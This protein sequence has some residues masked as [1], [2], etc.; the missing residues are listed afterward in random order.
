MTQQ[1]ISN[2]PG[3]GT[4]APAA[5]TA[6]NA[7]FAELYAAKGPPSVISPDG[8]IA[9][10]GSPGN[11]LTVAVST[12]L[13]SSAD[14]V[15]P[16]AYTYASLPPAS[17][18]VN[19]YAVTTDLGAVFSNGVY[20][21]ILFN[22]TTGV[23]AIA[24]NSPLTT[25]QQSSAYSVTL[26][27][28]GG[29]GALTWS[30][31]Q[32][33]GTNTWALSSSGV[34]T[35]TPG[36]VETDYLVVQVSDSTG[37]VVQKTVS[38]QTVAAL[39]P[40]ATPTFSPA[41]GTYTSTQT[42][43]ISDS[44]GSSTIY[45]TTNGS[46]PTTGSPVYSTPISVPT[47]QTLKAIATAAGFTQSAVGSAS[48]TISAAPPNP[49]GINFAAGGAASLSY[50]N[51]PIF[52]DRV[53]E[54]RGFTDPST[55]NNYV[56]LDAN[57]WPTV[58]W[59]MVVYE[60]SP[61]TWLTAGGAIASSSQTVA[62]PGV[63]TTA[64]QA[65]TAN[66]PVMITGTP[67]G[68]FAINTIYFVS[69]TGLTTTACELSATSGGAGIQCTSSS[70]CSIVPLGK[71][72]C[73]FT[74]TGTVTGA[75]SCTVSNI[76]VTGSGATQTTTF[77]LLPTAAT[78][79]IKVTGTATGN[80]NV[81]AYLPAY[82]ASQG[83]VGNINGYSPTSLF[84]TEAIAVYKGF[85]WIRAMWWSNAWNNVTQSTSTTRRTASNTKC[86]QGWNGETAY[87]EGFPLQWMIDFV[88]AC[89]AAGGKTGLWVC[90]PANEDGTLSWTTA[91]ASDLYSY[92]GGIPAGIPIYWEAVNEIWNA[93]GK[94]GGTNTGGFQALA[95]AAGYAAGTGY[96]QYLAVRL[97]AIAGILR[98]QFGS[99]F[100][101]DVNIVLANQTGG[102]GTFLNSIFFAYYGTQGWSIP[103]DI[104]YLAVAPYINL[105]RWGNYT[106]T[107]VVGNI[108]TLNGIRYTCIL[109]NTGQSPPN[110]TYWTPSTWTIA[111]IYGN[112]SGTDGGG[113]P[114]AINTIANTANLYTQAATAAYYG[115]KGLV[116]YEEDWQV[117]S[118]SSSTPNITAVAMDGSATYYGT[119]GM[120][121]LLENLYAN[122]F[123]AGATGITPF[124]SGVSGGTTGLAPLDK[125]SNDWS[126]L[127]ASGSPR[128]AAMKSEFTGAPVPTGNVISASGST[129]NALK[130]L[131]Y[132][133]ST[134]P[135]F[136]GASGNVPYNGSNNVTYTVI[137]TR[138][139]T[140]SLAVRLSNSS[141]SAASTNVR[142]NGVNQL[143]GSG[144]IPASITNS[145]VTLGNIT[146]GKGT[147]EI[148][149]GT[150]SSQ[151]NVTV[152][153]SA[154][155]GAD[156][157]FT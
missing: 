100:G 53:R 85:R 79:A 130:Y 29:I 4:T 59:G 43:T 94:A 60:G 111:N 66:Q 147:Y 77:D 12:A 20:W 21:Q 44:T 153:A 37:A 18:Y 75:V 108:V 38:L 133:G 115:L 49:M 146:L 32:V 92:N 16:G 14:N 114:A 125:L 64:T 73:G 69:A 95:V 46:T 122:I 65:F 90:S 144:N 91:T 25:A 116:T 7:N 63:F 39:S 61:Q 141:G 74:G 42:V 83:N 139:A 6:I 40:A 112:L 15:V 33:T 106:T 113:N 28:T 120:T 103:S 2:T 152:G 5:A 17:S 135:T 154:N 129:V 26:T 98:T 68:G 86:R 36:S 54:S 71:F 78:F 35:G 55:F 50:E 145:L 70:A 110:A 143:T 127:T 80:Q 10:T 8:S 81:F 155:A 31:V 97:H 148:T 93:A 76:V 22:P 118:E 156:L 19:K 51:F 11:I 87:S 142:V 134:Y 1:L 57:G 121:S 48:Y 47:T 82:R 104:G 30:L 88:L 150:G 45:Y 131:D 102:N 109:N 58:D 132:T 151:T 72:A 84:T 117:N 123:N 140:Y 52:Q 124:E 126:A 119:A 138:A 23:L 56:A 137:C 3:A 99:R 96:M 101:T 27:A 62:N 157:V 24:S 149:L 128:L 136:G 67:P 105:N 89:Q 41:A 34:L 107:F 13:Q 9:V